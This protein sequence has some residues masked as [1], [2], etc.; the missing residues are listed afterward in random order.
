MSRPPSFVPYAVATA[1]VRQIDV[2]LT[3]LYARARQL[4]AE[5]AEVIAA[6]LPPGAPPPGAAAA[7]PGDP[8]GAWGVGTS[9]AEAPG[10]VDTR[11]GGAW[12]PGGRG[13]GAGAG[14]AGPGAGTPG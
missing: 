10:P 7:S 5:R 1:R 2:E 4:L 11:T 6:A 13:P 3:S 14:A 12:L 9:G 8:A